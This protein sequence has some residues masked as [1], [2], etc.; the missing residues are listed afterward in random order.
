MKSAI[1]TVIKAAVPKIEAATLAG[2]QNV[3]EVKG[4]ESVDDFS[5]IDSSYFDGHGLK[6]IQVKKIMTQFQ[7]YGSNKGKIVF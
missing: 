4:V 2:L 1:E 5:L 3:L 7:N 6:D